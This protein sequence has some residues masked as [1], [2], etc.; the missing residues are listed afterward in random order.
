MEAEGLGRSGSRAGS[1]RASRVLSRV[2]VQESSAPRPQRARSTRSSFGSSL[3]S[4]SSP[5]ALAERGGGG[6][7]RLCV[8]P[9]HFVR[10]PAVLPCSARCRVPAFCYKKRVRLSV[11]DKGSVS[12]LSRRQLGPSS[13]GREGL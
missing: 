6:G 3:S 11:T 8:M 4:L 13:R 9:G 1:A 12:S 2:P 10:V 7:G 5:G